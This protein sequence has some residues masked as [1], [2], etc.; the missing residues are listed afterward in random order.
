MDDSSTKLTR[1][2]D[3]LPAPRKIWPLTKKVDNS[4][5]FFN[6]SAHTAEVVKW[7]LHPFRVSTNNAI[8]CK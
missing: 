4:L 1:I 5:L 3:P 8:T 2:G 7:E 6:G